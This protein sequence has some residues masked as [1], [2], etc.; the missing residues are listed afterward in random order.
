MDPTTPQKSPREMTAGQKLLE[1]AQERGATQRV[2]IG[3]KQYYLIQKEGGEFVN[4]KNNYPNMNQI[5]ALAQVLLAA[6]NE[7]GDTEGLD[8]RAIDYIDTEGVHFQDGRTINHDTPKVGDGVKNYLQATNDLDWQDEVIVAHAKIDA[9]DDEQIDTIQLPQFLQNHLQPTPDRVQTSFTGKAVRDGLLDYTRKKVQATHEIIAIDWTESSTDIAEI[10]HNSN[11]KLK[12]Q[13]TA[14]HVWK[15]LLTFFQPSQ[16]KLIP[17]PTDDRQKSDSSS[18]GGNKSIG[19]RLDRDTPFPFTDDDAHQLSSSGGPDLLP[20]VEEELG[21]DCERAS[22]DEDP[23]SDEVPAQQVLASDGG[24]KLLRESSEAEEAPDS[25]QT[26]DD[27]PPAEPSRAPSSKLL[28]DPDELDSTDNEGPPLV[29]EPERASDSESDDASLPAAASPARP[30]SSIA[31][32]IP[33]QIPPFKAPTVRRWWDTD[34]ARNRA[35][36]YNELKFLT[37]NAEYYRWESLE[38]SQKLCA[39]ANEKISGFNQESLTAQELG[40]VKHVIAQRE[41]GEFLSLVNEA[42]F[43]AVVDQLNLFARVGINPQ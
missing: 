22:G 15:R 8:Q 4:P 43:N 18:D 14:R 19:D 30:P 32:F 40:I 38:E 36:A 11:T 26:D 27:A 16:V 33:R 20:E 34:I 39:S 6:H 2:N 25:V 31:R 3:G 5:N 37:Q 17:D 7:V 35:A 28:R 42:R 23:S 21:N 10:I 13:L 29:P 12:A 41:K 24:A 9:G 1:R